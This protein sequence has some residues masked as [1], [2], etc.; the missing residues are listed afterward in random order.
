MAGCCK[1][2]K[3]I[4]RYDLTTDVVSGDLNDYLLARWNGHNEFPKTG[5]QELTDYFNLRI[6]KLVY[7]E[8]DRRTIET[9]V[10]SDY[11][12][13]T[14]DDEIA[15]DEIIADLEQDGIDGEQLASDFISKTTLYR[16]FTNCLEAEK[17]DTNEKTDS[18][19]EAE[20]IQ[21]A[22]NNALDNSLKALKSL[23]NK[24]K[25]PHATKAEVSVPLMLSC[26][27]CTTRVRF[28]R[29][30]DRG[31]ICKEHMN[32]DSEFADDAQEDSGEMEDNFQSSPV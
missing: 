16:H 19:W 3:A 27:E 13:L 30:I 31:Y 32:E 15:K 4:D 2:G 7:T 29:A 1:V 5:L 9:Q 8:N 6:L 24:G 11:E 20:S 17:E 22:L 21:Y 28:K 18:N 10:E 25:I 23:E 26:P 14:G 12:A